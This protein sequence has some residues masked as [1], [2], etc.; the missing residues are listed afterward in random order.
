MAT[1]PIGNIYAPPWM[2]VSPMI[3]GYDDIEFDI[4]L[5]GGPLANNNPAA[6]TCQRRPCSWEPRRTVNSCSSMR[7]MISWCVKFSSSCSR[8]RTQLFSRPT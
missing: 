8:Q 3:A 1:F 5:S 6:S 7:I 2:C 4:D